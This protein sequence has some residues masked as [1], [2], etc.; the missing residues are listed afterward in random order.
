MLT[1]LLDMAMGVPVPILMRAVAAII[2]FLLVMTLLLV[3]AIL[4]S[5]IMAMSACDVILAT[6]MFA[7]TGSGGADDGKGGHACDDGGGLAAIL[8]AHWSGAQ[9]RNGKGGA[10]DDC[11]KLAVHDLFPFRFH[12]SDV[13][14]SACMTIRDALKMGSTRSDRQ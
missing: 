1:P 3:A 13:K 9:A 5:V 7:V 10:Q 2:A 14:A 12:D 11:D 4:V 6:V 8:C